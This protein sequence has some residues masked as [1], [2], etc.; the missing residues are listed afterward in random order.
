MSTT[1][2]ERNPLPS[3]SWS[4]TKSIDHTRFGRGVKPLAMML[5]P[6][7]PAFPPPLQRYVEEVDADHFEG[8]LPRIT[9]VPSSLSS[10]PTFVPFPCTHF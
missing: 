9:R 6:S 1:V 10:V 5:R 8:A 7:T 2:S 3:A 4:A